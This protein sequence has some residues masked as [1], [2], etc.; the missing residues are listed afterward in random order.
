MYCTLIFLPRGTCLFMMIAYIFILFQS[1]GRMALLVDR[2]V[3]EAIRDPV[4]IK[5]LV[6]GLLCYVHLRSVIF[7]S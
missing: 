5:L 6:S 1:L 2:P 4:A 3:R 7:T